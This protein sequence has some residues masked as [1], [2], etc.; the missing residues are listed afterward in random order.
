MKEKSKFVVNFAVDRLEEWVPPEGIIIEGVYPFIPSWT[1]QHREELFLNSPQF[2][3]EILQL[4]KRIVE[5]AHPLVF[6]GK[7]IHE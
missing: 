3:Q 1:L 6:T 2:Q 5:P 4:C 7:N